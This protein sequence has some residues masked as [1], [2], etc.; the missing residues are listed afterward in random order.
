[1]DDVPDWKLTGSPLEVK[2]VKVKILSESFAVVGVL[3]EIV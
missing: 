3:N 1:M 2:A